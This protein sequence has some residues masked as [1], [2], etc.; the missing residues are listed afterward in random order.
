MGRRG[1]R[2]A[3]C[4]LC[5]GLVVPLGMC[6][7]ARAERRP[8][9]TFS[10]KAEGTE[11]LSATQADQGEG[12]LAGTANETVTFAGK[13]FRV[14]LES[15]GPFLEMVG[16]S[17]GGEASRQPFTVGG[18]VTRN[19]N[20]QFTCQIERERPLDCGTKPFSGLLM[21]L[22]ATSVRREHVTL[23]VALKAE[24]PPDVFDACP[25]VGGFPEL[26]SG[27]FPQVHTTGATVFDKHRHT[28]TFN[29]AHGVSSSVSGVVTHAQEAL[30]LTLH[31]L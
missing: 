3:V 4:A 30:K 5:A 11:T 29:V 7:S 27:G 17:K 18:T 28:L 10:V 14:R 13:P 16:L 2:A 19:E 31:R 24:D 15:T 6:A 21:S 20:G 9:A 23:F 22:Q 26:F 8:Q 12:C 25:T 1:S